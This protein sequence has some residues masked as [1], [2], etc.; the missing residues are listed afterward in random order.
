MTAIVLNDVFFAFVKLQTATDALT[1]GNTEFTV[2]VVLSKKDA[3]QWNKDY[4]KNKYKEFDNEEFMEKFKFESLPF[5]DQDEQYVVKFRKAHYNA[6]TGKYAPEQFRPRV[7]EK[8]ESGEVVDV[9]FDKMVANGSRGKVE[10]ST[11]VATG[12]GE[13]T[14]LH[15][16]LV[17]DMIEY[18]SKAGGAVGSSFGATRLAEAPDSDRA[19]AAK[20]AEAANS[21]AEEAG[22]DLEDDIPF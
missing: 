13:F 18:E 8:L 4:P 6:K 21:A 10:F 15:S 7:F 19:A 17:E 2:D 16:I 14:Q 1:K 22:D 20:R 5:P 9:T 3:K 12:F 11:Y